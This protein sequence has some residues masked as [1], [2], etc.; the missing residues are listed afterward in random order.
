[1]LVLYSADVCPY[2]QRTR[3]LLT[4][5]GVPFDHREIDLKHKPE[6]FLRLSP[7][8]KAPLL[9]DGDL[10]LYESRVIGDYLAE[11]LGWADAYPRD[12]GLRARH[13]LAMLQFDLVVLR[14][15]YRGEGDPEK[16][17]AR[18]PQVVAELE[19]LEQTLEMS[20]AKVPSLLS[21]HLAPFW[22]RFGWVRHL[23]GVAA[24]IEA[25]PG[26][27]RWLDDAAAHPAV[28]TTLP[29]R[30]AAVHKYAT[31]VGAR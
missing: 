25:R 13:R 24:L 7:T 17:A 29:E 22:V 26:L 18:T 3:A 27:A 4:H 2:A 23:S 6:A 14:A 31:Q 1:M 9:L 16:I 30:E 8:G 15:F 28:Q 11:S 21:F 10:R 5:L 12:A 19:Q 20:G